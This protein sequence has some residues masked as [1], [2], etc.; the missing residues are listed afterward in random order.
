MR[1]FKYM[2]L[3]QMV[4]N[5]ISLAIFILF[6]LLE[7]QVSRIY[8]IISS[9]T[10]LLFNVIMLTCLFCLNYF[11]KKAPD[12]PI[13]VQSTEKE[14]IFPLSKDAWTTKI[15][16]S[17]YKE[18]SHI[19]E[20]IKYPSTEKDMSD[21][22]LLVWEIASRTMDYIPVVHNDINTLER[23][24]ISVD[25]IIGELSKEPLEEYIKDP[26]TVPYKVIA[27]AEWLKQNK[28]QKSVS[29]FGYNISK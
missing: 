15:Y 20:N 26:T 10:V 17:Y 7:I 3:I 14:I 27:I 28:V 5:I 6:F 8:W 9:G 25:K 2:V 13:Q 21:I 24:K 4:V 11:Q 22:S 16:E 19:F 1:H 18:W 12:A 29:A 23:N